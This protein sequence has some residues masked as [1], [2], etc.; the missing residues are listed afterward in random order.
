MKI[1][2]NLD[3]QGYLLQNFCVDN[4]DSLDSISNKGDGRMVFLTG[5]STDAKYRHVNVWDGTNFKAL[6]YLE[7]VA[8][9]DDFIALQEKVDSIDEMLNLE[10]SQTVIDTWEEVKAFLDSVPEGLELMGLLNGKLDKTGGTIG[11]GK[12][13]IPLSVNG[14]G[15]NV[16]I[17]LQANGVVKGYVNWNQTWGTQLVDGVNT[18]YRLGIKPDGTPYYSNSASSSYAILTSAGGTIDG[19]LTLTY[20]KPIQSSE[21][22]WL[23]G[24]DGS[25]RT[26]LGNTSRLTKIQ[27]S[28]TDLVHVKGRTEYY[29]LDSSNIE[30]YT[31]GAIKVKIASDTHMRGVS[32]KG[33]YDWSGNT[34]YGFSTYSY[35]IY[36]GSPD[37]GISSLLGVEATSGKL[38]FRHNKTSW[39]AWKTIAFTNSDITGYA[40]GLKHS[41]GTVGATVDANG[42]VSF[43]GA[44]VI[45]IDGN[46]VIGK[47]SR[48]W[49]TERMSKLSRSILRLCVYEMLYEEIPH[50]VSINEAVELCKK[51]DDDKARPFVNGILNSVKQDLSAK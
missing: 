46:E 33:W 1:K 38:L 24:Y 25:Y 51:F 42:N 22:N 6:A 31:A 13:D 48:G 47:H 37:D 7:D 26:L 49:K 10:S 3:L 16:A 40:A 15:A 43:N 34:G 20:N 11:D 4:Y 45:Q 27:S 36:I 29:I 32:I 39:S 28:N 14:I 50:N 35:G 9:N 17:A 19:I 5:N 30:N 18:N 23:V 8:M 12:S 21:G 2:D 41:N 44:G